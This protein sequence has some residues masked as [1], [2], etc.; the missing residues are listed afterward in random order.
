MLF[1]AL[2]RRDANTDVAFLIWMPSSNICQAPWKSLDFRS[3]VSHV[4]RVYH[5]VELIHVGLDGHSSWLCLLPHVQQLL[6]ALW[7]LFD[8][9]TSEKC[10]HTRYPIPDTFPAP[11]EPW[12]S[13]PGTSHLIN[14]I[15]ITIVI[16]II[17]ISSSSNGC[18]SSS[19]SITM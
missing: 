1:V 11:R 14:I 6:W 15:I 13:H 5:Q 4:S 19:S 17:I 7:L 10:Q 9:L 8:S 12:S 16:I 2:T 18:S 3:M